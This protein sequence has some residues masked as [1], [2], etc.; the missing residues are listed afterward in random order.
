MAF[1]TL[2]GIRTN[3]SVHGNGRPL[4]FVHGAFVSEDMWLPQ[5]AFFAIRGYKVVTYDLRG[6]GKTDPSR[7]AYSVSDLAH[8]LALLV[9]ALEIKEYDICGVSLGGAVILQAVAEG[10]INPRKVIVAD[11]ICDLRGDR[12][13]FLL[14]RILP[15]I[16]ML[17]LLRF[18]SPSFWLT[19]LHRLIQIHS[20]DSRMFSSVSRDSLALYVS[21]MN[22]QGLVQLV[23]MLY[24]FTHVPAKLVTKPVLILRGAKES[25]LFV[26]QGE[27]LKQRLPGPVTEK[28]FPDSGHDANLIEPDLFNQTVLDYLQAPDL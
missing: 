6:H 3:Y 23:D 11:T 17:L 9:R 4:I 21:E 10:R 19:I 24:R 2:G 1:V 20:P 27:L 12:D 16:S 14:K 8:D 5:I 22:K 7:S 28:I 26:R 25:G 18:T 15:R 13:V